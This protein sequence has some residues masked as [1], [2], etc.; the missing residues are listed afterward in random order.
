MLS[1]QADSEAEVDAYLRR[2]YTT[3]IRD[4]EVVL[5]EDLDLKN[6]L[7]GLQRKLLKVSHLLLQARVMPITVHDP[8]KHLFQPA[9]ESRMALWMI[10]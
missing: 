3:N 1:V 5:R 10:I 6:H 7:S 2:K 4:I 9:L 8:E